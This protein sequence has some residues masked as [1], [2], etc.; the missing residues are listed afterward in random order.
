MISGFLLAKIL[1]TV[2]LWYGPYFFLMVW[3]AA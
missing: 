1:G 2:S 3:L